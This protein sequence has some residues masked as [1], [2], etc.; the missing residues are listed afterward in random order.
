MVHLARVVDWKV[1]TCC[2]GWITIENLISNSE[3]RSVPGFSEEHVLS[4]LYSNPFIPLTENVQYMLFLSRFAQSTQLEATQTFFL[5]CLRP[6]WQHNRRM[7]KCRQ[8]FFFAEADSCEIGNS[9]NYP[10]LANFLSGPMSNWSTTWILHPI[11]KDL[12]KL[13]RSLNHFVPGRLHRVL[14]SRCYILQCLGIHMLS[15]VLITYSGIPH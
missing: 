11:E 5:V 1:H 3:L 4:T 15:C 9:Q 12:P 6:I 10:I 8:N 7:R 13:P 14:W 2:K